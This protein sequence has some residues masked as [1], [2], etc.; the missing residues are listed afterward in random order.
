[1]IIA[2]ISTRSDNK[3]K[4]VVTRTNHTKRGYLCIFILGPRML[5]IA[6]I[7]FIE[8]AISLYKKWV[9]LNITLKRGST[10]RTR[11]IASND[12][13]LFHFLSLSCLQTDG[14]FS[15][16]PKCTELGGSD[17]RWCLHRMQAKERVPQ[18]LW[19]TGCEGLH[20][21][22]SNTCSSLFCFP[23]FQGE[24]QF[25]FSIKSKTSFS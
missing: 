17:N 20:S 10:F 25:S 19:V 3:S 22:P 5:K 2:H 9:S 21:S 11:L 15:L 8:P 18:M 23:L 24:N 13:L 16:S 12:G 4:N 7:K 14:E 6:I 1:M